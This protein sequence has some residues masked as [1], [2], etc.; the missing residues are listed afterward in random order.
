MLR[1]WGE[2]APTRG[3]PGEGGLSRRELEVLALVAEGLTNR[4]IAERL[5]ISEHTAIR[6]VSNILAKLGASS[7]A[8]A[9]G[10]AGERGL[11]ATGAGEGM[12]SPAEIE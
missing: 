8:A 7:R 12:A 3:G 4:Q 11:L 9:V 1:S 6:H 10:L 5:V 2:R